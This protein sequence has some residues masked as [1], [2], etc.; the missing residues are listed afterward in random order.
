MDRPFVAVKA[1][2]SGI[3]Q[4]HK[5]NAIRL[6]NQ[7]ESLLT[8]IVGFSIGGISLIVTDISEF[9]EAFSRPLIKCVLTLLVLSIVTGILFRIACYFIQVYNDQIQVYIE[10]AFSDKEFMEIDAEDISNETDIKEVLRRLKIDFG[11]DLSGVLIHYEAVPEEGKILILEDVKKHY[12]KTADWAKKDY[13]LAISHVND[14]LQ[15]AYGYTSYQLSAIMKDETANKWQF[16]IKTA[17]CSFIASC[18]TF[19]AVIIL[20]CV[21]Y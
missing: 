7:I 20:L 5:E 2:V 17:F 13:E 4:Q 10:T 19:I 3:I 6:L 12:K 1:M 8:W 14:T 11:E 16:W 21:A 15:K 9:S 18:I